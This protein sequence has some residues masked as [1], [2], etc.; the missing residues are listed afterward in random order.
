MSGFFRSLIDTFARAG[1]QRGWSV[2]VAERGRDGHVYYRESAGTIT[3]Y[4]EFGGGDVV[5]IVSGGRGKDWEKNY[6]WA[7]VRRG[8]IMARVAS[9]VVR[10]KAPSCRADIDE[11]QGCIYLRKL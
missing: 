5:A 6:P 3:F 4:W 9:E 10:Q 2:D 7:A 8:E 1:S 11:Q